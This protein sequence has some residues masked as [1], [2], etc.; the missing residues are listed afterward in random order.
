VDVDM[1]SVRTVPSD[2]LE[3]DVQTETQAARIDREKQAKEAVARAEADLKKKKDKAVAK[4]RQADSWLTKQ[5]ESL[6]DDGANALVVGNLVAVVGLSAF[7]GYKAIGLYE[8][9]KLTWQNI[10]LGLGI[11]G[12]VGAIEGVMGRYLYKAK[13]KQQ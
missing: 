13:G 7:L 1:P 5:F 4:G 6:G 11:V 10:G 2:F 3:H 9:G 8:R 12:V